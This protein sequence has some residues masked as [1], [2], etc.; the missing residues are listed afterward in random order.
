MKPALRNQHITCNEM[1]FVLA[2]L[3]ETT[4]NFYQVSDK[5]L[6]TNFIISNYHELSPILKSM[7]T[8]IWDVAR[9]LH[10]MCFLKLFNP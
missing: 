4:I 9:A 6:C 7:L 2:K 5:P 1:T 8:R 10:V 3:S